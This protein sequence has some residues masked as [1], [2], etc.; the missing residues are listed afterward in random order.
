LAVD[1]G[2]DLA[3]GVLVGLGAVDGEQEAA[4]FEL[5]VGQRESG[6]FG[7]SH[8]GGEVE[9]DDRGVAGP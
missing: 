4:R 5:D 8:G 1:D 2:D 7:A 6:E 9:Q 3:V